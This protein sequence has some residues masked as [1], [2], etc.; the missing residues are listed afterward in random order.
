[1][2]LFKIWLIYLKS[3][4][5]QMYWTLH[6][7]CKTRF[8]DILFDIYNVERLG[9]SKSWMLKIL[10]SLFYSLLL[11]KPIFICVKYLSCTGSKRLNG[12]TMICTTLWNKKMRKIRWYEKALFCK[13]N[14]EVKRFNNIYCTPLQN[15][16]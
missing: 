6:N 3:N 11:A 7:L 16:K 15:G 9:Y 10:V 8:T 12:G 2:D 13:D 4:K 14:Q 5:H 1:M